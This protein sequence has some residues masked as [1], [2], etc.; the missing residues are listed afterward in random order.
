M[1]LTVFDHADSFVKEIAEADVF[2]C[3][4][5]E[6]VNGEHSL[7]IST[8]SVL[9]QGQRVVFKDGM[10]KW[11]EYVV[12]GADDDHANGTRAIGAYHCVWSVQHDLSTVYGA[13]MRPG[14]VDPVVCS[15]ALN[16]ALTGTSRWS[17]AACHVTTTGGVSMYNNSAWE[18]IADV[19]EEFGGELDVRIDVDPKSG[20]TSR[21]IVLYEVQ[22]S[23]DVTR[24]FDWGRDVTQIRRRAPE[25]AR[26]CRVKPLGKGEESGDGYGRKITI[27]SV[28]GGVDYL[29]D[30]Q[31]ETAFRMPDGS[32]GWEYPTTI[33]ENPECE[34]PAE[35]KAWAQGV[36]TDYTRPTP[37]YE[38]SVLQFAEAGMDVQGVALGDVVHVVDSGFA[39]GAPLR[40]EARVVKMVVN[41][42]DPADVALTL[43]AVGPRLSSYFAG[44]DRRMAAA[45]SKL[46]AMWEGSGGTPSTSA[47]MEWLLKRFNAEI[48]ST[49]GYTYIT[50]GQGIRTYNAAVSDPLVGAE[51]TQC[52]EVKGGTVRIGNKKTASADWEWKTVFVS[53]HI[54][55]EVVTAARI[56]SGFIGSPSGNYINFDTGQAQ[57]LT[58][59]SVGGTTL[60]GISS[61]ASSAASTASSAASAAATASTKASSA[62]TEAKK[63]AGGTNLLM[64]TNVPS[65]AKV[66][67]TAAR[68]WP[69]DTSGSLC[70]KAIVSLSASGRPASGVSY[71]VRHRYSAGANGK[72]AGIC[73]YSGKAAKMTSGQ[74][75]TL[76]CWAKATKGAKL[77]FQYGQT[78]YKA[79][80][81]V[82]LA[83]GWKR[84]SFTF[85]FD[86]SAVGGTDGARIYFLSSL[87]QN[88]ATDVYLCGFKLELGSKA[89]DWSE[90]PEDVAY[91][92]AKTLS[93]AKKFTNSVSGA[94]RK[95]TDNQRKALDESFN[96]Q[97]VFN[98]LTK[99]STA[100]GLVLD[101]TKLYV[102]AS[103]IKTGTLDAKIL[104]AGL[105]TD[106]KGLTKLNLDTGYFLAKN[107]ELQNC[108]VLGSLTSGNQH[109]LKMDN[110][111]I[112]FWSQDASNRSLGTSLKISAGATGRS[113]AGKT[114]YHPSI[115][116]AH[117]L[118]FI[119]GRNDQISIY[120]FEGIRG[121]GTIAE[122]YVDMTITVPCTYV[123]KN[124][125]CPNGDGSYRKRS[126]SASAAWNSAK[127]K[128][129]DLHLVFVR[130]LC[131][132]AEV[133]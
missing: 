64:D 58:T 118:S 65:L 106:K 42:L 4:R 81:W 14:V 103:Y 95:Y 108:T 79:S 109:R 16:A 13:E 9:Q 48:N 39:P 56:T 38:A 40:V 120:G 12:T 91:S 67:A 101:G 133:G 87:S 88:A 94:D 90:A 53:G 30:T 100:Q 31:A 6:A 5:T 21:R 121:I 110:G 80:A 73:F 96:Q 104:K 116:F 52:T 117:E 83:T 37:S 126:R 63:T 78:S 77:K 98:R 99:N 129:T 34:T 43:G 57:L 111:T 75:Y 115:E 7:D 62:L 28:N 2:S 26:V 15:V 82:T 55:A 123:R 119:C 11:H 125:D 54:A 17:V 127:P 68:Y 128:M 130:G 112:Q 105:L 69:N 36:M 47:Y 113:V 72:T 131:V 102:N 25:G 66:A 107:A 84:Y 49:D 44:L 23:S 46:D 33:I 51:A 45:Q 27:A 29:R 60:G 89:S 86:Q 92:N 18:R 122:Q 35:L 1:R 32:G 85:K 114:T 61:T 20:V 22:G 132:L 19:I 74:E 71:A 93:D 50:D 24:R 3:V 59:T 70:A 10:E 97:K 124:Y 8:V 41:E 76:S